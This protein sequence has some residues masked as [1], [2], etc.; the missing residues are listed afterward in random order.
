MLKWIILIAAGILGVSVLALP[1]V[2]AFVVNPL[3]VLGG[4]ISF[5]WACG[6][7]CYAIELF[8]EM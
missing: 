5:P 3:W 8:V 4:F 6:L 1:L 7:W 2:L